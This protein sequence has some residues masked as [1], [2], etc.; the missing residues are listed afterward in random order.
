MFYCFTG[1]IQQVSIVWTL[2]ASCTKDVRLALHKM[3]FAI[4]DNLLQLLNETG[5]FQIVQ[6]L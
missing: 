4:V 1:S 3:E 5:T 2:F 6:F